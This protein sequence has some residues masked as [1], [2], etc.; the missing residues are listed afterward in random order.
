MQ[1]CM[2][3]RLAKI[4]PTSEKKKKSGVNKRKENKLLKITVH[5][6]RY[7]KQSEKPECHA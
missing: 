5:S 3:V 7:Q 1:K 2:I 6:F 4:S